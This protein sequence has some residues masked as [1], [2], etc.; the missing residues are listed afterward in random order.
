MAPGLFPLHFLWFLE[1]SAQVR[2]ADLRGEDADML[3]A[4][5]LFLDLFR[6]KCVSE[7]NQRER[8]EDGRGGASTT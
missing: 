8:K 3:D 4:R 1:H 6:R 5:T 7:R 2:V